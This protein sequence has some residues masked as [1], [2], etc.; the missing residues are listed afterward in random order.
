MKEAEQ[1]LIY[2][3]LLDVSE[4]VSMDTSVPSTTSV[5]EE[6]NV[7]VSEEISSEEFSTT[8]DS[9]VSAKKSQLQ[10]LVVRQCT[11]E[12][13]SPNK[14]AVMH[15]ISP[16]TVRKWIKESGAELPLQ[17]KV[18][19]S[20]VSDQPSA[21]TSNTVILKQ[22]KELIT[23]LKSKWPCLTSE[24]EANDNSL[25]CPK[26]NFETSKKNSF[27]LHVKSIHVECEQCGQVFVGSRAKGQLSGHLKK[28][29]NQF[30]KQYL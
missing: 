17:Y 22:S 18:S 29:R 23:S 26:C 25:K 13:I 24:A 14:L 2:D 27:D 15:G 5:V 3:G 20:Q 9:P 21:S 19:F 4:D 28:H 7:T 11:E 10:S 16:N 30:P 8:Q 12:S 6:D 1:Y